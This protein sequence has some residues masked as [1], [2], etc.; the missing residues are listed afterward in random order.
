MYLAVLAQWL[1]PLKRSFARGFLHYDVIAVDMKAFYFK[2]A[3]A[4]L[5]YQ[6]P[7]LV[8]PTVGC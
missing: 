1:G 3:E 8:E 2:S 4:V 7:L 5:S 6:I